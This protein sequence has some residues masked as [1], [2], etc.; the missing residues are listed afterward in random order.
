MMN[1]YRS[2]RHH[3][4]GFIYRQWIKFTVVLFVPPLVDYLFPNANLVNSN[5]WTFLIGFSIGRL[6]SLCQEDRI[7]EILIDTD[8]RQIVFKYYDFN[9]GQVEKTLPFEKLKIDIRTSKPFFLFEP[10]RIYF[11]KGNTEMLSVS[12]SKDG[13][14]IATLNELKTELELLTAPKAR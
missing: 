12:Q 2:R 6:I 14:S 8:A 7:N 10:I 1:S 3:D 13:F 5:Y 4:K 11:L 9:E